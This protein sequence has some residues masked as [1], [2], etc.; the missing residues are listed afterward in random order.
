MKQKSREEKEAEARENFKKAAQENQRKDDEMEELL[1]GIPPA[2]LSIGMGLHNDV[3]YYGSKI[4]HTR[5]HK[6]VDAV[7]TSER[8][9]YLDTLKKVKHK[10]ETKFEGMNEIKD[11]F[12]IEYKHGFL[13]DAIS[14]G[15]SLN[16]SKF[17]IKAYLN[18]DAETV[19]G[20]KIFDAIVE[21]NKRFIY[22]TD[23]QTHELT[24]LYILT[25]FFLQLFSD[26]G[27]MHFIGAGESGKTSQCRLI[28]FYCFNPLSL[29]SMTESYLYNA[30]ES[31]SGTII[32]DDL[33]DLAEE[34]KRAL[35]HVDKVGY[36]KEFAKRG[37]MAQDRSGRPNTDRYFCAF[38]KN[39]IDDLESVSASRNFV[40]DMTKVP[41]GIRLEKIRRNAK[42]NQEL[43][44]MLHVWAMQN[45]QTIL[46]NYQELPD[47]SGLNSRQEEIA[48]PLLAVAKTIDDSLYQKMIGFLPKR[49]DKQK[50]QT[51]Q[52]SMFV[53]ALGELLKNIKPTIEKPSE[54]ITFDFSTLV[55]WTNNALEQGQ[56]ERQSLSIKLGR[57]FKQHRA[58]FECSRSRNKAKYSTDKRSF[59]S[60]L[61]TRGYL[62]LMGD[63]VPGIWLEEIELWKKQVLTTE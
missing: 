49:A 17:S 51:E 14:H 11:E 57:E 10:G 60:F 55:L 6:F 9:L 28:S 20:R 38:V 61:E 35:K 41:K 56:E 54:R 63:E 26:M 59:L 50:A 52:S 30:V 1:S 8:K 40:V 13:A 25:T 62:K 7:I 53:V 4:W 58:I 39:S 36:K 29:A 18:C 43:R 22:H 27:R 3:F 42:P 23:E 44:D 34:T 21:E 16:D 47:I 5:L 12:G 15:W 32:L 24:A 2:R 31:T 19:N 45:Y 37:S 46:A 48:A 33:D